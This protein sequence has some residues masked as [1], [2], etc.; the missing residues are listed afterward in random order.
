MNNTNL[1]NFP[2]FGS[3]VTVYDYS[4]PWTEE[5]SNNFISTARKQRILRLIIDDKTLVDCMFWGGRYNQSDIIYSKDYN[6]NNSYVGWRMESDG[7]N[8]EIHKKLGFKYNQ[9]PKATHSFMVALIT[10]FNELIQS[11][12]NL[13]EDYTKYY[14]KTTQQLKSNN[15]TKPEIFWRFVTNYSLYKD[16]ISNSII[17]PDVEYYL[18]NH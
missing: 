8:F 5:D 18:N 13:S 17:N 3:D 10:V 2:T 15:R 14:I 6:V 9:H 7:F 12:H 1:H 16:E 4:T 11:V